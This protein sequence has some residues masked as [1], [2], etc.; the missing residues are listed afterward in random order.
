MDF[1]FVLARNEAINKWLYEHPLILGLLFLAI[2]VAVGASGLYGLMTSTT[3]TKFGDEVSGGRAKFLSV[4]RLLAGVACVLFGL[5]QM[6]FRGPIETNAGAESP[7]K[8][9]LLSVILPNS[10]EEHSRAIS[11]SASRSPQSPSRGI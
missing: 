7:R 3:R 11:G 10:P 8:T 6:F 4:I 1:F 5:Y 2:G 9:Q